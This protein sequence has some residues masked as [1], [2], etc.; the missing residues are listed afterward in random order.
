VKTSF[1][2]VIGLGVAFAFSGC[3]TIISGSSQT[4]S[5]NSTPEGATVTAGGRV[6]GKTPITTRLPRETGQSITFAKEGY[7]TIT[8]RFETRMNGW[9]WGNIVLGGFFGS[10]TD[11]VSGAVNE[12][13]PSQ[14]M[15]TLTPEGTAP[16][17]EK[18]SISP[19]SKVTQFVTVSYRE[20]MRDLKVGDGPYLS[21]LLD[22]LGIK[23]G[24]TE[25]ISKIRD[26][27]KVY[28][29]IPE[30]AERVNDLR[31]PAAPL[32]PATSSPAAP[33]PQPQTP[34]PNIKKTVPEDGVF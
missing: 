10:T 8:M 19:E 18:T 24:K 11:S 17:D 21:S 5:F 12:Y 14:Y 13:S 25:A 22:L 33:G 15:V 28:T 31:A 16:I 27:A 9:F 6:I 1:I 32:T 7:T 26:L 4:V 30:F 2:A 29:T 34:K 23:T 20:L 3:A